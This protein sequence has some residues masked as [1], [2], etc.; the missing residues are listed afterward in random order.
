MTITIKL[1]AKLGSSTGVDFNTEYAKFFSGLVP[2][3]WPYILGGSTNFQGDQIVLLDK[4][5]SGKE[6]DTKAIILDGKNFDYYF[7]GH[8]LS[9]T[10]TTVRLSTLGDSYNSS[11]GSFDMEDGHITNVLTPIEISGLNIS[12]AKGVK[13]EMHEVIYGLMGGGHDSGGISQVAALN[14]F[15]WGQG[16]NVVGSAGTD[17]Y[18]GT[19]YDDTIRGNGGNDVLDGGTGK[20]VAVYSGAK[21]NYT[22]T[23]NADGTVTVKDNRSGA[24]DGRDTLKNIE[25]AKFSDGS[26]DLTKLGSTNLAPTSLA[27]SKSSVKENVA[28]GTT[29]GTLSAKD[30]EGKTLSYTLTDNA[31]GLFKLDGNKLV[32]AKAVDYEAVKSGKVTVEVSDGVNKVAKTFT[33]AIED[34]DDVNKAPTSLALSKSSVKENVK[35]GTTVGTFSAV[36]PEGKTLSYKLTDNAGGL[37][38]LSGTNLVTAKAIDYEKVQKD[39]VTLQVTDADGASAKKTFTIKVTDVV[40]TIAGSS[41][42]E[43]L[44]GGIG[45]DLIK[46]GAGNDTLYG[47]AGNDH[48]KGEK[49]NDILIGGK[50]ADRLDGGAGN[51]TA[52]YQGAAKGVTAS[53]SKPSL[54]TNDAKG[55]VYVSIENL[56]GSKYADKLTGDSKANILTGGAGN[57]VLKGGAGNDTL[58]GGK[59]ADDLYGGKGADTFLFKSLADLASSKAKTD[60]IFDFSQKEKDL[61][62]LTGIDAVT[63][64]SG[65]QAFSF[66]G[67]E[68]FSKTAGELRYFKE[69]ADTYVYGDVNGDG[70]SD[71][72]IHIDNLVNF[73]ADDFLL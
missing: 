16:H 47:Y 8:T 21:S 44:K 43:T 19:K 55:D 35:T 34:V 41:K 42:G 45:A 37:F 71:F 60:T 56:T 10:L 11:N 63:T 25:I 68:K 66:I 61:I 33:I 70:K 36:D 2:T 65:N 3:G 50:G 18:T 73:K 6:S 20:D 49:G 31:G 64:K 13:G 52:S 51:D 12:N 15:V 54:N 26:V 27:L 57:D 7:N 17:S 1:T 30:P 69:K 9:G 62:D 46:G 23:K 4:I 32:T 59:G 58:I 40:E 39:T 24:N 29:V 72:A 38:K 22:L 14:A 67:T 28:V 5:V 53:L 48:L